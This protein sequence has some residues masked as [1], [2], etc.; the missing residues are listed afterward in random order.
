LPQYLYNQK[1]KRGEIKWGNLKKLV[2]L[3]VY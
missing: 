3:H 1:K 2:K